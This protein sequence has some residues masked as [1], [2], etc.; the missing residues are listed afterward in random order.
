MCFTTRLTAATFVTATL[1]LGSIALPAQAFT[2]TQNDDFTEILNLLLDDITGLTSVTG[3]LEGNAAAFGTF[4]NDPFGL[5][6]GVVLSTGVV[7]EI[8]GQNGVDGFFGADLSTEFS[9]ASSTD[10]LFDTATLEISFDADET[11]EQLFFQYVFGS[12]EFLE[13]AGSSF[14]DFFTL[15]LNGTN[16]ALL[17]DSVGPD[18]FVSV[19]NL[20]SSSIGPFSSEYV[21]NPAGPGTLTRL[22]GYTQIL[23]FTGDVVTGSNTLRVEIA[24]V[25]DAVFDSAVLVRAESLRTIPV[26]AEDVPES[27]TIASL[28]LLGLMGA[29]AKLRGL[30]RL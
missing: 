1:G 9:S 14:N 4:E 29:G 27:S 17:S 16:L 11:V 23:T 10:G 25:A 3:S 5:G 18:D 19:N 20:A 15:E 26:D 12:E 21:D 24:D 28:I 30:L 22:D 2:V 13:F 7:E 8:P 6:S